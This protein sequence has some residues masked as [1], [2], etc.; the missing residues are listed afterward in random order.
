MNKKKQLINEIKQIPE[1]ILSEVLD[2]LNFLKKK[3][4]R[5]KY[6]TVV[7]S[8]SPLRKGWLK[9]EESEAWKIL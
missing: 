9:T 2:F 3:T 8:E 7:I 4:V 1:P 5:N 6:D